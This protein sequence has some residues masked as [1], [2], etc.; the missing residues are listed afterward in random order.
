MHYD[1][2]EKN[3]VL[4][5]LQKEIVKKF[6]GYGSHITKQ[7]ER[8]EKN[9]VPHI[10]IARHLSLEQLNIAKTELKKDLFCEALIEELV[11]TTVQNNLFEESSNPLN[12][13][14]FKLRNFRNVQN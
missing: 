2:S 3:Q 8:F 4:I 10:T 1:Q 6:S 5:K 7:D 13:T 14:Y 11:L 12:K 9:F